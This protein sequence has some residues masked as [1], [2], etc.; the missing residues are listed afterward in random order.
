VIAQAHAVRAETLP[1]LSPVVLLTQ[2]E[3]HV[4]SRIRAHTQ[5]TI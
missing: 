2:H 1:H 4:T 5:Q 3:M